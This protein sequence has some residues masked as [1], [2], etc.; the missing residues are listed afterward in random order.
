MHSPRPWPVVVA[1]VLALV[2][3][4]DPYGMRPGRPDGAPADEYAPE[5]TPMASLLLNRGAIDAAQVDAIWHRWFGDP[6]STVVG[7]QRL[8]R[9]V[10]GLNGVVAS[11]E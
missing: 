7:A 10:E 9:F 6:L 5:A 3:D 4:L 8:A 11:P 1:E 2:N